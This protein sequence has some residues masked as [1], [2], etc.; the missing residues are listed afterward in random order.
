VTRGRAAAPPH[1]ARQR[2]AAAPRC[3][4]RP[5]GSLGANKIRQGLFLKINL[6]KVKMK[7]LSDK[8]GVYTIKSL[9]NEIFSQVSRISG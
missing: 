1:V 7:K 6:K 4:A 5:K 3:Q 8:R 9:Y 2:L